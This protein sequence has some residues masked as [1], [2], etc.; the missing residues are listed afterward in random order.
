M[1]KSW[2]PMASSRSVHSPS[3]RRLK[4]LGVMDTSTRYGL[5]Q[6]HEDA[7]VGGWGLKCVPES[8]V[9]SYAKRDRLYRFMMISLLFLDFPSN[10]PQVTVID[11]MAIDQ[12]I[13]SGR[14]SDRSAQMEASRNS[15]GGVSKGLLLAPKASWYSRGEENPQFIQQINM[16]IY[17]YVYIYIHYSNLKNGLALGFM[18]SESIALGA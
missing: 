17:I 12:S 8:Y 14:C 7:A 9:Y 3:H 16:F 15:G 5:N 6:W 1:G 13:P 2:V 4:L 11:S 10:L 18:C